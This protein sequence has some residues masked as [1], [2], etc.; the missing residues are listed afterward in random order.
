MSRLRIHELA[1]KLKISNQD[2]IK[3]LITKGF[4]IKTHSNSIDELTARKALG[5]LNDQKKETKRPKTILRRKINKTK[6]NN[7]FNI[8][9]NNITNNSLTITKKINYN[10]KKFIKQPKKK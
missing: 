9:K 6:L 10:K 8:N 4:F 3:K 5:L 1:K 2:L 7:N